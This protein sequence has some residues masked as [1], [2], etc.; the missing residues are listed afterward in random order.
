MKRLAMFGA[1]LTACGDDGMQPAIDAA[2]PMPDAP[3]EACSGGVDEDADTFTDCDDDDCWDS[4]ACYQIDDPT[5]LNGDPSADIDKA[6]TT[7]VAGVA[8]FYVTFD[9]AWPPP[10]T[11]HRWDLRFEIANDGNT[12]VAGVTLRREAGVETATYF[13]TSSAAT[14]TVRQTPV[15]VWARVINV[16][17]AGEKYYVESGIQA[18]NPGTRVAD[19]V[20]DAPA[21][22]P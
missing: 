11:V 18:T 2:V 4:A 16:E 14:V 12:P 3:V 21:P 8:T 15:G 1:L 10:A 7:L 19:T 5:D 22:L 17:T 6:R 9:A 20:V 13:G